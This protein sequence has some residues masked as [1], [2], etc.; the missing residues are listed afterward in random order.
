MGLGP[1]GLGTLWV[2]DLMSLDSDGS[3]GPDG[4]GTSWV[5]DLMGLEPD[6]V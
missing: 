5:H 4:L 3:I 2:N 1:D 6:G